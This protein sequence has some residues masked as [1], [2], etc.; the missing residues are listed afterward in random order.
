MTLNIHGAPMF[1][2]TCDRCGVRVPASGVAH[3]DQCREALF[4]E[5]VRYRAAL[6]A[7]IATE[8]ALQNPA[9]LECSESETPSERPANAR[10]MPGA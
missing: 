10:R 7:S 2:P 4:W 6:A 8:Q 9:V 3:C 1:K 5:I